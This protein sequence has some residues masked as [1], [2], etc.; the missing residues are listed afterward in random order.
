VWR[1]LARSDFNGL[2]GRRVAIVIRSAAAS[3]TY[4]RRVVRASSPFNPPPRN[5]NGREAFMRIKRYFVN[6]R[7]T[8]CV[9]GWPACS[10]EDRYEHCAGGDLNGGWQ[11]D[12]FPPS[13]PQPGR[14]PPANGRYHVVDASQSTDGTWGITYEIAAPASASYSWIVSPDGNARGVYSVGE[15]TGVLTGYRWQQPAGC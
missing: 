8:D 2:A 13:M 15:E 12:V 6:S 4:Q 10:S 3:T 7:F 14:P 5:V 11:H 9:G 1:S